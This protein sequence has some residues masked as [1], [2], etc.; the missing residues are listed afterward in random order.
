MIRSTKT[1][2]NSKDNFAHARYVGMTC[3][4][5]VF[6]G[7]ASRAA[8]HRFRIVRILLETNSDGIQRP[9][10]HAHSRVVSETKTLEQVM[11]EQTVFNRIAI[12]PRPDL[13][14]VCFGLGSGPAEGMSLARPT[15]F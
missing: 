15:F 10:L 14:G 13:A 6:F 1:G 4:A 8:E 11:A 7:S 12:W 2:A 5:T 3:V 9:V